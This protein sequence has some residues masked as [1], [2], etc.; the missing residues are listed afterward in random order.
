ME[1]N[2]KCHIH[3]DL[4]L[5]PSKTKASIKA[6]KKKLHVLQ[7]STV[8]GNRHEVTHPSA[9]ILRWT[10]DGK[11][12]VSCA[13]PFILQHVGGDEEHGKQDVK[14]GTYEIKHEFEHD[15][16]ANELKTVVD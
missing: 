2:Q 6:E 12:Y 11:E 7:A 8:S 3:G 9:S 16:Y 5:Y 13:K 1:N 4:T 10:K 15:P 14:A